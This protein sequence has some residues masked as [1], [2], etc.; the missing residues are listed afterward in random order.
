M[1]G[2]AIWKVHLWYMHTEGCG[3]CLTTFECSMRGR[4]HTDEDAWLFNKWRTEFNADPLLEATLP[5]GPIEDEE[6]C[7]EGTMHITGDSLALCTLSVRMA[8]G[9][10]G[11]VM[12]CLKQ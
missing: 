12:Y 2:V 7:G 6:A 5:L 10:Q 3:F 8:G 1:D 9:R 11:A 4:V